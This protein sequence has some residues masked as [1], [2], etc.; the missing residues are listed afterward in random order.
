M[1]P[2]LTHV[3]FGVQ[4]LDRTIEFY[5]K[6][7]RLHVVHEREEHGSRVVW[8]GERAEEPTFVLVFF[9]VPGDTSGPSPLQHL[10]FALSSRDEV[11]AAAEAARADGILL[12]EPVY[13]GPIV[14]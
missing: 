1:N 10:G 7:V 2:A 8:L 5:R 3:A 14:G 4:D 9:E 11:D 12:L 6:H 13:A